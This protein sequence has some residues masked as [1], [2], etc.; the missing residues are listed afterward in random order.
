M[1]CGFMAACE[2]VEADKNLLVYV[3]SETAGALRLLAVKRRFY[4][5]A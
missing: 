4:V 2:L 3:R 5:C 1:F